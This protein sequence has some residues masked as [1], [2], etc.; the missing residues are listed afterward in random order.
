MNTAIQQTLDTIADSPD[1]YRESNGDFSADIVP[2]YL[3]VLIGNEIPDGVS[4]EF[5]DRFT[6]RLVAVD[7]VINQIICDRVARARV[8]NSIDSLINALKDGHK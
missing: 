3:G 5:Q 8:T 2:D 7:W 1:T 4:L 6:C